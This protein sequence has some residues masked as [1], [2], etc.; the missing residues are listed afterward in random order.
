MLTPQKSRMR[1]KIEIMFDR[2]DNIRVYHKAGWTVTAPIHVVF[3]R[4]REESDVV[5][6]SYDGEAESGDS[7]ARCT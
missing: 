4:I 5:T 3:L 7:T 2:M 6:F 1:L